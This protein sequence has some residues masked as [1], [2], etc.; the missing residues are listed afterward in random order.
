MSQFLTAGELADLLH[1][2]AG[3]LRNWRGQ[4]Y[5]PPS[6]KA[7]GTVLYDRAEVE[8]WIAGQKRAEEARRRSAGAATRP[9]PRPLA[10]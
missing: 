6:F 2:P 4:G 3:T 8:A 7:G 1:K 10:G 9:A 5:G